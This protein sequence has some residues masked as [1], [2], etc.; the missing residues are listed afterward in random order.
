[1]KK[2]TVTLYKYMSTEHLLDVLKTQLLYLND[3]SKLNDPFDMKEIANKTKELKTLQNLLILCLTNSFQNKLMWAHYGDSYKGVCLTIEVPKKL[4]YPI[5]YTS[6]RLKDNSN[7][8]K[9]IS[10]SKKNCK[11]NLQDNNIAKLSNENK[12]KAYFKDKRW[13]YEKEY[14]IVFDETDNDDIQQLIK[15]GNNYFYKV[16]I[17]NIY[18]GINFDKDNKEILKECQKQKIN[19]TEMKLSDNDYSIRVIKTKNKKK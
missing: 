15:D 14:R 17:K 3:G 9:M 12:K 13:M 16:H 5:C 4:V 18:L 10:N 11:K 1:M 7:L 19:I 6:K 2:D 8:N